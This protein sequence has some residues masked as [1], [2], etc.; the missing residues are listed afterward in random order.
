MISYS[1]ADVPVLQVGMSSKTLS[2]QQVFD[3]AIN[4]L[5]IRLANIEGAELPAPYG[6]KNRLVSID[7][8]PQ[9]LLQ[10]GLSGTDVANAVNSQ[11]LVIPQGTTS[12]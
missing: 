6:G 1:A 7:L 10:R 12:S 5:R 4:F 3:L 2:E 11:N 8:D 9:R